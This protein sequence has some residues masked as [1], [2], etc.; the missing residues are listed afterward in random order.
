MMRMLLVAVVVFDGFCLFDSWNSPNLSP[1]PQVFLIW[2]F[3]KEPIRSAFWLLHWVFSMCW[4]QSYLLHLLELSGMWCHLCTMLSFL[5]DLPPHLP[6]FA[7]IYSQAPAKTR[8][9][10]EASRSASCDCQS[11]AQGASLFVILFW[12]VCCFTMSA[13]FYG[14]WITIWLI[15]SSSWAFRVENLSQWL[16]V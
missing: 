6:F 13:S 1:L 2:S 15:R 3:K 4:H 9:P 14:C 16:E 5:M 7:A 8:I 12:T 11:A 10:S